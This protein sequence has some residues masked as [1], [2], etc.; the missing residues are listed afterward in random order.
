MSADERTVH[1]IDRRAGP[2]PVVRMAT[3]VLIA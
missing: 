3:L 2:S 1:A